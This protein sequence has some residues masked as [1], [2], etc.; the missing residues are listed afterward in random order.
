MVGIAYDIGLRAR[1]STADAGAPTRETTR[2]AAA[3]THPG[4]AQPLLKL[5]GVPPWPLSPTRTRLANGLTLIVQPEAIS[6]SVFVYGSVRTNPALQEPPGKE[7]VASVLAAIYESGT[8]LRDRPAFQRALD[9]ADATISAG[10]DFGLQTTVD[11]FDRAVALLAENELHPRFDAQ[12]FAIARGSSVDQLRSSST[13]RTTAVRLPRRSCCQPAIPTAPT[14]RQRRARELEDVRSYYARTIRPD[15]TTI[16]VVGNVHPPARRAS[17]SVSRLVG[18]RR[19]A[20][21]HLPSIPLNEGA[22]LKLALP[23]EQDIETL[24]QLIC[25]TRSD[26]DVPAL[27]HG[28]AVLGGGTLGPQQSRLFRDLRQNAGLV[29]SIDSRL[30]L[31]RYR[32]RFAVEFACSPANEER[33][34]AL[35]DEQ[36]QRMRREPV[37]SFELRRRR[38]WRAGLIR[39]H[40]DRGD[41]STAL[42]PPVDT[43]A[44][45]RPPAR[46]TGAQRAFNA[47]IDP[48]LFVRPLRGHNMRLQRI[49]PAGRASGHRWARHSAGTGFRR[50]CARNSPSRTDRRFAC[51]CSAKT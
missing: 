44:P 3:T 38:R 29:Y 4:W 39:V 27:L 32:S 16:V 24:E 48:Q 40:A 7:G 18:D 20:I 11:G 49:M 26:P 43:G 17:R 10:S 8:A 5:S 31:G 14:D 21:A 36:I 25:S 30:S 37:G 15:L 19:A 22:R 6:K 12:T 9:A 28:N 51:G 23:F 41:C 35:I 46:S 13:A 2:G 50:S 1:R 42:T 33:L 34:E 47:R 45:T